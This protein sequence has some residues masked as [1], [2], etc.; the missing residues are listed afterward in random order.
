[1]VI[2]YELELRGSHGMAAHAYPE[3]LRLVTAG[4]LRP[5]ELITRTIGLDEVPDALTTMDRP[6]PGGMCLIAPR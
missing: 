1:L 5:G 2:A 4:V 3:L 6:A